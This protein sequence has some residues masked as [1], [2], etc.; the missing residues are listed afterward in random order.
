[1]SKSNVPSKTTIN[2]LFSELS[3]L[4]GFFQQTVVRIYYILNTNEM[5]GGV[6]C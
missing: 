1:M 3:D 4:I 5:L 6:L 2:C